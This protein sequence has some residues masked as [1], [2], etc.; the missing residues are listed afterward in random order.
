MNRIADCYTCYQEKE[1]IFDNL[2]CSSECKV[3]FASF[4]HTCKKNDSEVLSVKFRLWFSIN[5]RLRLSV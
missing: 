3:A 1:L 5:L 4:L 2:F